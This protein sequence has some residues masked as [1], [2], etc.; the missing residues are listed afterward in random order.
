MKIIYY[1]NIRKASSNFL[2]KKL[3]PV[4]AENTMQWKQ[5]GGVWTYDGTE[6]KRHWRPNIHGDDA[7]VVEEDNNSLYHKISLKIAEDELENIIRQVE[8][9]EVEEEDKGPITYLTKNN[10]WNEAKDKI[11]NRDP[12]SIHNLKEKLVT[13]IMEKTFL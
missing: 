13:H 1:S 2:S 9:D 5:D 3:S 7:I 8:N 12:R 6:K 10:N 11:V 4:I